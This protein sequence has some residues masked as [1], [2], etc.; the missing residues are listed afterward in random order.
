MD[1]S[2]HRDTE[3]NPDIS[4]QEA[5]HTHTHTH[6][7]EDCGRPSHLLVVSGVGGQGA[8]PPSSPLGRS[9]NR[10]QIS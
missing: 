4:T 6:R 8:L 9:V 2:G 1:P 3:K 10:P 7:A 5:G